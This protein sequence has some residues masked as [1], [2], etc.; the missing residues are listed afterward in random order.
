MT[1]GLFKALADPMRVAILV[2]LLEGNEAT[3]GGRWCLSQ[4]LV[5][6]YQHDSK[7]GL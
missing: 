4:K 6:S 5:A 2:A 1:S 7:T 3:V